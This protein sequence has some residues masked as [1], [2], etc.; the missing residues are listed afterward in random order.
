MATRLTADNLAPALATA[1]VQGGGPK[2]SNVFVANATYDLID[3]TAVSLSGGYIIINGTGFESNVNVLV[4]ETPVI[5]A[6]RISDTEVRAQLPALSSGSKILYLVNT[7]TGAIGTRI[8]GVTY[9]GTP[10]WVTGSALAD[11][12][13]NI[14]LSVQLVANSD[15]TVTYQLQSGSTLPAG[16]TLAANGLLSGTVTGISNDT[17]YNFTVDATDAEN[18]DSSRA[19]SLLISTKIPLTGVSIP[20]SYQT[21]YVSDVLQDG[22]SGR[23]TFQGGK[24]QDWG[25]VFFGITTLTQSSFRTPNATSTINTVDTGHT[26]AGQGV[27]WYLDFDDY[28]E[29]GPDLVR[30]HNGYTY[31]TYDA[32]NPFAFGWSRSGSS[33]TVTAIN[34]T[35]DTVIYTRTASSITG[36][37]RV[38]LAGVTS[39]AGLRLAKANVTSQSTPEIFFEPQ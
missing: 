9:S 2:I 12:K 15:S 20:A 25:H 22:A 27:I 17:L 10:T 29:F 18:Q 39:S 28:P 14:P 34:P 38:V 19:F 1:I 32:A 5:S 4:D 13:I 24:P 37:A 33:V 31:S 7:D 6:T 35:A 36:N 30:A 23:I 11:G 16:L 8:N 21:F 3:D 26:L